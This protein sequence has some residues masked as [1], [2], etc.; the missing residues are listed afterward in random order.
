M[1]NDLT[2]LDVLTIRY[3]RFEAL[4][5][6][7]ITHDYLTSYFVFMLFGGRMR[8]SIEQ[9]GEHELNAGELLVVPAYYNLDKTALTTL[10][11]GLM[12][13]AVNSGMK[14]PPLGVPVMKLTDRITEDAELLKNVLP[15][16]DYRRV[17]LFDIWY[18]IALMYS[19][20]EIPKQREDEIPF[21]PLLE[22]LGRS[23]QK[24]LTLDELCRVSG[25]SKS[26]LIREFRVY[27]GQ[28]PMDYIAD[29][30]INA[31]KKLLTNERLTLRE[32]AARCGFANEFYLSR[33]FKER[34][35][36]SPS[37]FRRNVV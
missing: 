2:G 28:T 35:G 3:S 14:K 19:V 18:Q 5:Q 1:K 33:V 16:S 26:A 32:I 6:F 11:I 24:K 23:Y 4:S 21:S 27:T 8:Y 30:R 9:G 20:P 13:V 31:V 36:V 29:L 15:D 17:I 37:E 25:Y 12:V 22:Y 10:D 7:K 34:T